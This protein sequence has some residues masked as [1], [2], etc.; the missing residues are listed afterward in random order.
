MDIID[1]HLHLFNLSEGQYRWL[2]ADN[3]PFWPD[4]SIIAHSFNEQDLSLAS[5]INLVGYVHIEAGFDNDQSWR[6]ID[7]IERQGKIKLRSVGHIDLRI[8][9]VKFKLAWQQLG[10]RDSCVGIRHILDAELGNILGHPNCGENL[11]FL[12]GQRALFELQFDAGNDPHTRQVIE[13]LTH[14]SDI[15]FV[16]NHTGFCPV[17]GTDK[18]IANWHANMGSLA[19]QPNLWVKCSGFEMA[20][21]QFNFDDAA[22]RIAS[23]VELFGL[24]R[25]M[26]ASNFPLVRFSCSYAQYWQQMLIAL[27]QKNLPLRAL[28]QSNAARL[29]GFEPQASQIR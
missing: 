20:D 28:V 4:K 14:Y 13:T 18:A 21:R 5:D 17:H 6:E 26:L 9:P 8:E 19:Q 29:Y 25:V 2:R 10:Q 12:N 23:V 22:A 11:A 24:N 3:P 7:W 1:P 15:R 16:L 27:A